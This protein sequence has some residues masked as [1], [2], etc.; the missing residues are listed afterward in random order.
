MPLISQH[1]SASPASPLPPLTP[2]IPPVHLCRNPQHQSAPTVSSQR[3]LLPCCFL[4]WKLRQ[5][6]PQPQLFCRQFLCQPLCLYLPHNPASRKPTPSKLP[7]TPSAAPQLP[8]CPF[9]CR[10]TLCHICTGTYTTTSAPSSTAMTD[11]CTRPHRLLPHIHLWRPL[12]HQRTSTATVP[13]LHSVPL[14]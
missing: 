9:R 10:C 7:G 8:Q 1:P 14:R 13:G 11:H 3:L 6:L 12:S 2:I 4:K 5:S